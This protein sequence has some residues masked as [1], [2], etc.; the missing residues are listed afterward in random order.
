MTGGAGGSACP[1]SFRGPDRS[2]V[3]EKTNPPAEKTNSIRQTNETFFSHRIS[4][5]F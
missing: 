1:S 3:F 2:R 4:K 5:Y